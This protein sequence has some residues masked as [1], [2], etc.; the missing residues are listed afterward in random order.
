VSVNNHQSLKKLHHQQY[1][2]LT[3]NN[4]MN[5]SKLV[6]LVVTTLLLYLLLVT[7]DD[8]DKCVNCKD[9]IFPEAKCGHINGQ[10]QEQP[11]YSYCKMRQDK[12][13]VKR[14]AYVAATEKCTTCRADGPKICSVDGTLYNNECDFRRSKQQASSTLTASSD[15]SKCV[16]K[17]LDTCV[18]SGWGDPH[19]WTCDGFAFDLFSTGTY[20]IIRS[21]KNQFSVQMRTIRSV[22]TVSNCD[23][24][25]ATTGSSTLSIGT[26]SVVNGKSYTIEYIRS[27]SQIYIDGQLRAFHDTTTVTPEQ[28]SE[29]TNWVKLDSIDKN[30]P[31]EYQ[32]LG[33]MF[34]W[35]FTAENGETFQRTVVEV[36]ADMTAWSVILPTVLKGELTGIAGNMDHNL[37]NDKITDKYGKEYGF[38]DQDRK[39]YDP[40]SWDQFRFFSFD[41]FLAL[42]IF[43]H[44]QSFL[45]NP[46][47]YPSGHAL[48][49][50]MQR[51]IQQE[52]INLHTSVDHNI[53]PSPKFADPYM[54]TV[55]EI[56]C[57]EQFAPMQA[58]VDRCM[59]DYATATSTIAQI[60]AMKERIGSSVNLVSKI[61]TKSQSS[62]QRIKLEDDIKQVIQ[63]LYS[64]IEPVQKKQAEVSAVAAVHRQLIDD[65]N[66]KEEQCVLQKDNCASCSKTVSIC[67]AANKAFTAMND[68][69][70]VMNKAEAELSIMRQQDNPNAS[71][72]R[73]QLS[74]L[75]VELTALDQHAQTLSA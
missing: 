56:V 75:K 33:E 10:L 55:A 32:K 41:G 74:N 67:D 25:D 36:F 5:I 7:A 50:T 64:A 68:H 48:Y 2:I 18:V 20:E 14:D 43:D 11:F 9:L 37:E 24:T 59:Y 46:D 45:L 61:T 15:G 40:K 49:E 30:N 69:S 28:F 38:V 73:Q 72:L 44:T 22:C 34:R 54:Q 21:D 29:S 8:K 42:Q 71:A 53:I 27:S 57:N 17:S 12:A 65:F 1:N 70:G 60:E 35:R 23:D 31:Y 47:S 13:F 62:E 58:Y 6:V 19:L 3:T 52:A 26:K 39:P 63:Q 51:Y 4:T 16:Q 66:Q